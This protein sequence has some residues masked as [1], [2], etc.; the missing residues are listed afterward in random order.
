[1]NHYRVDRKS[2]NKETNRFID[3]QKFKKKTLQVVAIDFIPDTLIV[4]ILRYAIFIHCKMF[5]HWFVCRT[6]QRI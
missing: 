4:L 6:C 3:R 5:Y 2:P 1:M